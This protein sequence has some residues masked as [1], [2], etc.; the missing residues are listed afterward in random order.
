MNANEI[1]G[2]RELE[3]AATPGP[4]ETKEDYPEVQI[5]S[6]Y[7]REPDG[8]EVANWIGAMTDSPDFGDD[9]DECATRNQHNAGLVVA[10]RNAL[11][12]LL[13]RV[14]ELGTIQTNL[15]AE[16]DRMIR[17]RKKDA[18]DYAALKAENARL[19]EKGDRLADCLTGVLIGGYRSDAHSKLSDEAVREWEAETK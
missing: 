7:R 12:S 13:D 4:W 6:D 15:E 19:K 8:S 11:P 1:K 17:A 14:E 16:L 5:V 9:E 2:L 18:D 3:A 10:M